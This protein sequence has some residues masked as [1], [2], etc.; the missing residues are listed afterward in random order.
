MLKYL[1]DHVKKDTAPPQSMREKILDAA[2]DLFSRKGFY[3]VSI[4]EITRTVGIKESSLYNHFRNK[5]QLLEEI[6]DLFQSQEEEFF[7]GLSSTTEIEKIAK[8]GKMK[9]FL[10]DELH[11]FIKFWDSPERERLWFVVSMEQ[12]RNPRAARLILQGFKQTRRALKTLIQVLIDHNMIAPQNSDLLAAEYTYTM[13]AMLLE[14]R[15]LKVTNQSTRAIK[16]TMNDYIQH[17]LERI[18]G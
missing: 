3:A 10:S 9:K 12:H 2:A 18:Q 11:C 16:K 1:E 15:L 6:L 7:S 5:D 13:R 8:S 17:F 14:Y 4:R